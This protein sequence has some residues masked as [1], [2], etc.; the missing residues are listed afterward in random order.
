MY[1]ILCTFNKTPPLPAEVEQEFLAHA[2]GDVNAWFE[3]HDIAA[4]PIGKLVQYAMVWTPDTGRYQF[5]IYAPEHVGPKHPA[6]L[7]VPIIEDGKFIDLLFLSDE[8]SFARATCRASWLG[9]ENLALPVVR[10]HAHPLDWLE[11]GC[12][13]VCHIESVSR[14]AL[15]ELARA[16][17]IECNDI[18][19]ALDAW[20]WAFGGEDDELARFS[21]DDSP[22]N[23]SAYYEDDFRWRTAS[24]EARYES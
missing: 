5:L 16:A 8:M 14:E 11:A 2:G 13:G 19:T 18:G 9:R 17:T 12:T 23:I 20:D 3:Q 24:K 22:G 10:L 7:A 1:S 15:A 4:A 21:I 6:E